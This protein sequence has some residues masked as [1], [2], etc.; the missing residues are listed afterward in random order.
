VKTIKLLLIAFIMLSCGEDDPEPN[1][2]NAITYGLEVRIPTA[3]ISTE[4]K[5]R[6]YSS[7]TGETFHEGITSN[8]SIKFNVTPKEIEAFDLLVDIEVQDFEG[9]EAYVIVKNNI[10]QYLNIYDSPNATTIFELN[11]ISFEDGGLRYGYI[12]FSAHVD[13][14]LSRFSNN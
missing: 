12:Y 2:I 13:K 11:P 14:W 8:G 4:Y 3:N 6:F 10:G 7:G 5:Y 9:V 1:F